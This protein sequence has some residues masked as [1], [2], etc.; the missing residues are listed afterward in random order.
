MCQNYATIYLISNGKELIVITIW[1]YDIIFVVSIRVFLL[2]LNW[3]SS[4]ASAT[5]MYKRGS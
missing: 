3:I 4:V 1:V 5:N 2:V